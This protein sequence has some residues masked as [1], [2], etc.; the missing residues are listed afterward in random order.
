MRGKHCYNAT[1]SA[2]TVALLTEFY[3]QIHYAINGECPVARPNLGTLATWG[4]IEDNR[5]LH[6]ASHMGWGRRAGVCDGEGGG[7]GE[8]GGGD[9]DGGGGD[10]DG[11]EGEGEGRTG[12]YP[13]LNSQ[14]SKK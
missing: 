10:G 12:Q 7:E 4:S 3:E 1:K 5:Q 9:G 6:G 8:G 2:C 13:Q 11:G 14:F